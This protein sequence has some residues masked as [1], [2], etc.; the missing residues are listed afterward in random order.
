MV[1]FRVESEDDPKSKSTAETDR[2]GSRK[3]PMS[4]DS[5]KEKGKRKFPEL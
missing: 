3:S 4:G 2:Q 1:E 5:E